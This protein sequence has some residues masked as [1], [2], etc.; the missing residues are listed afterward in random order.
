MSYMFIT[1]ECIFYFLFFYK[2]HILFLSRSVTKNCCKDSK[3]VFFSELYPHTVSMLFLI[4]CYLACKTCTI[5]YS[6]SWGL[7]TPKIL[8]KLKCHHLLN[9]FHIFMSRLQLNINPLHWFL[10]YTCHKIFV[11]YIHFPKIKFLFK[12]FLIEKSNRV[13]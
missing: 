5:L 1:N 8:E 7:S 12:V 13:N 6:T 10:G 3:A 2:C 9:D 11:A 4:V